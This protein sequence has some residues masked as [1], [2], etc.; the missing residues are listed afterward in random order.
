MIEDECHFLCYCNAYKNEPEKFIADINGYVP[1]I[2]SLQP[3]ELFITFM[4]TEITYL[5][6]FVEYTWNN[7][8]FFS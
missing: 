2:Q 3:D 4:T 5:L 6:K 8:G 7:K 1:I